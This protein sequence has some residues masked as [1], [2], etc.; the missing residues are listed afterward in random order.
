MR[1]VGPTSDEP[2]VGAGRHRT[3]TA[4]RIVAVVSAGA[5]L[6]TVVITATGEW[7]LTCV[8]EDDGYRLSGIDCLGRRWQAHAA[9]APARWF[10][11]VPLVILWAAATLALLA[12]VAHALWRRRRE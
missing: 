7:F 6:A 9:A 8:D 1:G 10:G 3:S 2:H 5:C 12:C 4:W 11:F